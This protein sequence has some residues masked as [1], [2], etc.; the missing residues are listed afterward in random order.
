MMTLTFAFW[1][2]VTLFA[3]IGAMRGWA[4]ELL[5][6]ASAVLSLFV[7][8]VLER[9]VPPVRDFLAAP[10]EAPE[11]WMRTGVMFVLVFFGYQTPNI[12]K[13]AGVRFAREKLSDSLLGLFL[14]A[15]NGFLIVST[16]WYFMHQSGYPFEKYISAPS[17]DNALSASA[18]R[19]IPYLAPQWLGIPVI[20]FAVAITFIFLIVIFI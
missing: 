3:I 2:F 15:V 4:K 8:S 14:G 7:L 16:I 17:A 11:F 1:L 12:Q 5:V 13:I 6:T 20:Y 10:N 18:L 19:L 9:Y